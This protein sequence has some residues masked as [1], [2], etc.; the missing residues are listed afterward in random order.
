MRLIVTAFLFSVSQ[1]SFAQIPQLPASNPGLAAGESDKCAIEGRVVHYVTGKPVPQASLTLRPSSQNARPRTAKADDEGRFS[2]ADLDP[3]SYTLYAERSGFL[4][5]AYGARSSGESGPPFNLAPG[6]RMRDLVFRL[7]PQA[8]VTG[9]VL[10]EQGEPV[11]KAM[12]GF[13]PGSGRLRGVGYATTNDLGEFR[14]SGIFPGRYLLAASTTSSTRS[15]LAPPEPAK[16]VEVLLP[17][18]YPSARDVSGA[19]PL[20][21]GPGQELSGL[22]VIMRRSPVYRIRGKIAGETGARIGVI[23]VLR[24]PNFTSYAARELFAYPASS[25]ANPDGSFEISGVRPGSYYLRFGRGSGD[26]SQDAE[27]LPLDVTN[28]DVDLK[29]LIVSFRDPLVVAGTVR[30]EGDNKRVPTS[31]QVSLRSASPWGPNIRAASPNPDGSFRIINRVRPGVYY[32][33][34]L[35]LPPDLYIKSVRMGDREGRDS[36]LNLTGGQAAIDILLGAKPATVTGTVK[37]DDTPASGMWVALV[38]G[39]YVPGGPT[40]LRT[41]T[42]D[43]DGRV[44]FTGVPPGEYRLYA[45]EEEQ[46]TPAMDA[47]YLRPFQSNSAKV[48]AKEGDAIQVEVT[49]IRAE[50]GPAR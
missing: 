48:S 34:L 6:Q 20:E 45:W 22:T 31:I 49:A 30:V 18:L 1:W 42:S 8:V 36:G 40:E 39:E 41:A 38:P 17:T 29:D 3:G 5:Q 50:G 15:S 9:K 19:A 10:D 27:L 11:E 24:E 32:V 25:T 2:L 47:D 37:L 4:K 44:R 43:L 26:T 7:I 46:Y 13:L 35:Q 23:L 14:I 12:V 33:Q 16:P 28:A 21:I